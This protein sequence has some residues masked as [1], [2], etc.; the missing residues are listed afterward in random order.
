MNYTKAGGWFK[1]LQL[2]SSA[3]F[4]IGHGLNDSQKVMGIIA[5]ALVAAHPLHLGMGIHSVEDI[6]D[7]V[8]FSCFF[9][10]S[11]GTMSGGWKIV[12]TMGTKITKV[13]PFEGV[14][15]E[16]SGALTLFLTEYLK[17]PVSTTH[18]IAGSIMGVGATKRLSAVRWGVTKDLMVAW[19]LTIPVSAILG[20]LVYLVVSLFK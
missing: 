12:K 19:L 4:S 8:A 20:A 15:A 1:Q 9:A 18:T 10:I 17:I 7:W 6:P 14:V 13:T 3:L 11:A 5:A 16:T 2:V